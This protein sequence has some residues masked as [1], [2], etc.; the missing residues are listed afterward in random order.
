M[1]FADIYIYR[2]GAGITLP[3]ACG[4][5]ALSATPPTLLPVTAFGQGLSFRFV[6]TPQVWAVGGDLA[7]GFDG[8]DA[9]SLSGN[10][11][12]ALAKTMGSDTFRFAITRPVSGDKGFDY[13]RLVEAAGPVAGVGRQYRCIA[14]V[15]TLP[16]D[17]A[18]ASAVDFRRTALLGTAQAADRALSLAASEVAIAADLPGRRIT[19]TLRLNGA[20]GDLGTLSASGTIDPGTGNFVAPFTAAGRSVTGAISGRFFGPQ[21]VEVG[22]AF[23][24]TVAASG[25]SPAYAVSGAV[26]GVR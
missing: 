25:A 12:V 24:A 22:V 15:P 3:S 1:T 2:F 23:G 16:A 13:V 4:G 17:L 18:S 8:R 26:F 11:E 14:G 6:V 10:V 20:D 7:V 19:V 5:L 9:Q 21:A